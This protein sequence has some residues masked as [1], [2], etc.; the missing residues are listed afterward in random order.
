MGSAV[1]AALAA[2]READAALADCDLE[3]LTHRELLAM[4]DDLEA[5]TCALPAQWHRALARA[6]G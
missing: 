4:P 6:A 3:T 2:L 1:Q 5:L